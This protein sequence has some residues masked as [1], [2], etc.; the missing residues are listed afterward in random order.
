MF[1]EYAMETG[2]EMEG[3]ETTTS[4]ADKTIEDY[5]KE[6]LEL[7]GINIFINNIVTPLIV[8]IVGIGVTIITIMGNRFVKNVEAKTALTKA[9]KK[10]TARVEAI[11]YIETT[12]EAAVAANMQMANKMKASGHKL[13]PEE[14]RLLNERARRT[15]YASLPP[16]FDDG[17]VL[18]ALIGNREKLDNIVDNLIEKYVYE[19]KIKSTQPNNLKEAIQQKPIQGVLDSSMYESTI[20]VVPTEIKPPSVPNTTVMNI[21]PQSSKQKSRG[22]IR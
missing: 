3:Y 10:D 17:G 20:P 22:R 11:K 13:T 15:I 9:M 21:T 19:Y 16:E 5:Q 6:Q 8:A 4:T 12:V 2:N 18:L 14:S 1:Q 7:Q